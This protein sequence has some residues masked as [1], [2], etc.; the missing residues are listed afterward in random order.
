M[1]FAIDSNYRAR[2]VSPDGAYLVVDQGARSTTELNLYELVT[3]SPLGSYDLGTVM[4]N[5]I[6]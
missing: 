6:Q 4:T 5:S 3:T 2:A 1:Y